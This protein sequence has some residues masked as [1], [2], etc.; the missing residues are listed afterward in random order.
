[1]NIGAD[2]PNYIMTKSVLNDEC[3]RKDYCAL[4]ANECMTPSYS[5]RYLKTKHPEHE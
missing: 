4:I 3:Q 1:M 5:A 2:I